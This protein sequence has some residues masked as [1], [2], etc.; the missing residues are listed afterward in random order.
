MFPLPLSDFFDLTRPMRVD[1]DLKGA[2][3]VL[4]SG[5]GEIVTSEYGPRL[6]EGSQTSHALNEA[7]A[8]PLRA[9]L[10]MLQSAY[11]SFIWRIPYYCGPISDEGGALLA[12]FTPTIQAVGALQRSL[13]VEGL[14]PFYALKTGDKLSFTYGTPVKYALHEIAADATA[15]A[16]GAIDELQ[17]T[18]NVRPGIV[19]GEE[20]ELIRPQCKAIIIPGTI[21]TGGFDKRWNAPVSFSWRQTL[22]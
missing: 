19:Q 2:R 3:E 14:P 5:G 21:D 8:R 16:T 17:L 20:I 10:T 13:T 12:G 18:S 1:Y 11:A 4:N 9:R 6:W 7:M 15:D 22:R